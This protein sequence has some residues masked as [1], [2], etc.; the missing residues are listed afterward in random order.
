MGS[1]NRRVAG[2]GRKAEPPAFGMSASSEPPSLAGTVKPEPVGLLWLDRNQPNA[3]NFLRLIFATA[4]LF[5][6]NWTLGGFGPDPLNQ[7]VASLGGIGAIAVNGFF[8]ISG[9]LIMGSWL[10][11]RDA[12]S[13]L[14]ARVTRIWPAFVV[15]FFISLLI[16]AF[17]AG[18]GWLRYLRSIPKQSYV[19][20]AFTLDPFELERPLSFPHNPYPK[21]VNGSMWTIRIE[22]C[23]YMAVALAGCIG[24]LRR[25][26]LVALFT[27]F[28]ICL[29]A[30]EQHIL[31]ELAWLRWARF[32]AY[33][34]AGAL[35]YL[36]R[37]NIP[38]SAWLALLCL[39]LLCTANYVSPY[40]TGPLAGTYLIFYLA[41]AAP[42]WMKKIGAKN[43]IS[44][45]VYLYAF[46]LQQLYFSYGVRNELPMNPWISFATVLPLCV[47]CGWLSWLY[48]EKPA[49]HR[50]R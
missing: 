12:D 42:A 11:R 30:Y 27:A 20:G 43:D 25:R 1:A 23:C 34:G 9:F 17:A 38:K 8:S 16:A 45:G 24:A 19:V 46:P 31:P 21:T 39:G 15:A 33:F 26:W 18:E 49:K 3:L 37:T 22:F 44:Y 41:Y 50:L 7:P 28:A 48:V 5:T 10:S 6:H 32:A 40:F 13:Y 47:A 2:P 4:V 36:Y 29:A 14:R 35:L